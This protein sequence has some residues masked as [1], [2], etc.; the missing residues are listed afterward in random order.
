L[1]TTRLVGV[2]CPGL[3]SIFSELKLIA[4]HTVDLKKI[5][6]AVSEYDERY[7]LA[8]LAIAAPGLNGNIKAFLRPEP[9]V[10][11]PYLNLKKLVKDGEFAGQRALVVGGSRGLG[12]VAA[13]LLAAGGAEVQLT[14]RV[15]KPDAQRV[16]DE[17]IACGG[18]ATLCELDVLRQQHDWVGVSMPSHLYYFASPLITGS[19][20]NFSSVLFNSFC[21]YFVSGFAGVVESLQKLG[22][23]NVFYPSTVFID[24][25]PNNFA[26]Y[27]LAKSAGEG[28]CQALG[29]KYSG[30]H[31]YYPRLPKMATDQTASLQPVQSLDPAPIILEALQNFRASIHSN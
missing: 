7:G 5:K 27:F 6:Y 29:Q 23:R 22:L 12:E 1:G 9:Q 28:L 25:R 17:I 21:D 11:P 13:K 18:L 31:L 19:A 30:M 26:E 3:H 14:Y 10:Q 16:V 24:E 4:S 8:L 2:K 20:K 15:G